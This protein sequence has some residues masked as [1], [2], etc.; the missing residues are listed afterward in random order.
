MK[1]LSILHIHGLIVAITESPRIL[2]K[3]CQA[4]IF[5]ES[6]DVTLVVLYSPDG[7]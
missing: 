2:S 6:P 7:K 5:Q 4:R 3:K 1:S